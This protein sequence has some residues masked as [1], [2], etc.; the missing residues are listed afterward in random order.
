MKLK[1]NDNIDFVKLHKYYLVK[2]I[3]ITCIFNK[4]YS[5]YIQKCL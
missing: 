3:Q 5:N 4:I 1:L 2:Y